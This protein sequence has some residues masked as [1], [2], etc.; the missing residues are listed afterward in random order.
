MKDL[1]VLSTI[2][3]A[4]PNYNLQI[5]KVIDALH[6][7]MSVFKPP[8]ALLSENHFNS[9]V[10]FC[11]CVQV[12]VARNH[13]IVSASL[14]KSLTRLWPAVWEILKSTLVPCL[15]QHAT[16]SVETRQFAKAEIIDVCRAFGCDNA[17]LLSM[18]STSGFNS[19][20]LEIWS[21]E[22]E[23]PEYQPWDDEHSTSIAAFLD[24][25]LIAFSHSEDTHALEQFLSPMIGDMKSLV[26]T[27]LKHLHHAF[28][29]PQPNMDCLIWSTHIITVLSGLH[30]PLRHAFV[31]QH[32][33]QAV[34]RILVA[35]TAELPSLA[36][37]RLKGNAV[38]YALWNL[39]QMIQST[40]GVTWIIQALEA[41]LMFAL[42]RCEPWIPYLN[43]DPEECFYPFL[44]KVLPGYSA[45]RSVLCVIEKSL[46][47]I[48]QSNLDARKSGD[49][50]FWNVWNAFVEL[51]ESRLEILQ[52]APGGLLQAH[53]RCHNTTVGLE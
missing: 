53:E 30:D 38:Q 35:M 17:T 43:D 52:T 2:N 46:T 50:P 1:E 21:M 45:Y 19:L 31:A 27:A 36:T 12:I 11:R 25:V 26:S 4:Y 20:I 41:K 47:K 3:P 29:R 15:K 22:I 24:T 8:K 28:H 48:Q 5:G 16:L 18:I 32:S 10:T 6:H 34:T 49:I 33:V 42:V 51:V 14:S 23:Y 7:C 40:D 13:D 9:A 39:I 37:A 44:K